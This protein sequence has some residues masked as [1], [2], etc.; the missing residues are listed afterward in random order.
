MSRF[1][2]DHLTAPVLTALSREDHA[3]VM[4]TI[5]EHGWPHPAMLSAFEVAA[6]DASNVRLALHVSSHSTR[7]LKANGKLSIVLA[8]EE[9][10]YYV[11]GDVLMRAASMRNAPY[12]A[13]FNL[14]VDSVLEDNASDYERARLISGIR[15]ERADFDVAA[16]RVI[17]DE[18]MDS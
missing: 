18:L 12:N 17:R 6:R 8:H 10:V 1:V 7:N 16:A 14:R 3:I 15:I 2:A 4:C 11:K 5:D 13:A 9:G